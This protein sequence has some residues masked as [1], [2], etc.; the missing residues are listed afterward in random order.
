M[1][2]YDP[3]HGNVLR[4]FFHYAVPAVFGLL[5]MSSAFMIDGLFLG[6]YVGTQALAAVN[7]AMPVWS[8][9]FSV[10]TMLSV[11]SSV[12]AGKYLG[13]NNLPAAKSIFTKALACTLVIS[14]VGATLGIL[15][16]D[17]IVRSLGANEQLIPLVSSYLIVIFPCAPAFLLGFCLYYFVRIDN[18]P[19]LASSALLI[20][21]LLNVIFDWWFI[22]VLE[23]GIQGAA[24]ATGLAH[25]AV[26]F[27]LVPYFLRTDTE[28]KP[29]S[30][31]GN[32]REIVKAVING[33]S[34]FVNEI[35]AGL[36]TLLL[37]WIMISRLGVEGVAAYTIINY[38][39]FIGIMIYYGIGES[40][41]PLVSKN[42]GARHTQNISA[43]ISTAL[44]STL[45]IAFFICGTLL[46]LTELLI[47]IFLKPE[48]TAT[49]EIAIRFVRYFWPA[50]VFSGINICLTAYF[51][52][53]HKPLQ[54]ASI[55]LSRSLLLP[56][57]F[58]FTLPRLFGDIGIFISVPIAEF[59]T[60]LLAVT[61]FVK[62]TPEKI[63]ARDVLHFQTLTD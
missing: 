28:L 19:F 15:F 2:S 16:L 32:W 30:L 33:F 53:C 49:I 45:V 63:V 20:S 10:V 43:Y 60:F 61:F 23:L 40:I 26:F 39:F 25:S 24:Y 6:N 8:G 29:T 52:A 4:V 57:L 50:F 9:L 42:F 59:L 12:I 22:V 17:P 27:I 11:G 47:N 38:L 46:L 51:T 44:L 14:L 13:Q 21:A 18:N 5:A 37:N 58:L 54:S 35:S 3:I 48:E 36:T 62:N 56:L 31:A 7:I 34:E 55:A 41:E 1:S